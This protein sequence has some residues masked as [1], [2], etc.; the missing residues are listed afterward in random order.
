MVAWCRHRLTTGRPRKLHSIDYS[1]QAF[2]LYIPLVVRI[3]IS[4]DVLDMHR[5]ELFYSYNQAA[6]FGAMAVAEGGL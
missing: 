1:R 2:V 6:F 3:C 5:F 4:T